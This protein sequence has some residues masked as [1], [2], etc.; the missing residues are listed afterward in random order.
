[1]WAP[2]LTLRRPF[3]PPDEPMAWDQRDNWRFGITPGLA[4]EVALNGETGGTVLGPSI[5][6][7][8]KAL[9]LGEGGA[10]QLLLGAGTLGTV[11]G[12]AIGE[13]GTVQ[14]GGALNGPLT[15]RGQVVVS[16]GL[17]LHMSG[18][19]LNLGEIAVGEGGTLFLDGSYQGDGSITGPGDTHFAGLL[20]PGNS[21]A[22]LTIEGDATL[23]ASST[24]LFEIA[25]LT[26]GSEYDSLQVGGTLTLGGTL[27]V[28]FSEGFVPGVGASFLLMEGALIE[29]SFAAISLPEVA[30]LRFLLEQ[31]ASS[32]RLK[33]QAVPL[34]TALWLTLS[35][36]A[37]LAGRRRRPQ[38]GGRPAR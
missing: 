27:S 7:T 18:S 25:G 29:G 32:V 16:A 38:G 30:G 35:A 10:L 33:V 2:L 8:V 26:R 31:D 22:L 34:P 15:N 20:S 13:N 17:A 28:D 3:Q 24:S 19:V 11:Q 14:G 6:T 9:H 23:A 1:V 4:H 21:P 5:D 36:C 12:L 37:V